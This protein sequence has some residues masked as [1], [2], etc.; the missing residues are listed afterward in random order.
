MSDLA[1]VFTKHL[2]TMQQRADAAL[3]ACGFDHLLIPSGHL[4]YGFLDDNAYPFT[5]NPQFKRWVPVTDNPDCLLVCTRGEKPKLAFYSPVDFW[6]KTHPVP[7]DFWTAHFDI[8]AIGGIEEA[9][10]LLPAKLE[11]AAFIGEMRPEFESFGVVNVNPEDLINHLHYDFAWKTEYEVECMRQANRLGARAHL[12]A[13]KAFRDGASEFEIHLAYLAASEH[14]EDQLPYTNIIALNEHAAILH[15][16]QP[17]RRAPAERRSFLIDAGCTVNGYA[18]DIT[19]TYATGNN[20]F[21]AMIER[22]DRS[23]RALC[24]AV[25][26]G[27]DYTQLQLLTH[28]HVAQ[29]LNE[30]DIAKGDPDALVAEGVTRTFFPHGIG[31]YIGAQVHDVGGKMADANGKAIPQPEDQP[32]LRLTRRI[33]VDQVFTIEPG[34][35]FIPSLLD[36]LKRSNAGSH[37]N[38]ARVDEFRPFGGIRIEDNVRVTRDGHE[39]LTRPAFEKERRA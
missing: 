3:E 6:H 33:E 11:R 14:T 4:R 19:R 37:V 24:D 8:H 27:M 15:Y 32:F 36:E 31:H 30:F 13:E 9:A 21:Q 23:Q 25:Q 1:A 7:E 20:D 2:E 28:R 29:I 39:N 18:S 12:A 16:N 38:W 26:P 35:Y 10:S 22:M 5:V 17:A 34:L